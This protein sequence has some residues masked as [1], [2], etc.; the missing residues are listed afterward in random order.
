MKR[1]QF[2]IT[3]IPDGVH[4][5]E[6]NYQNGDYIIEP[7]EENHFLYILVAGKAGVYNECADGEA[8]LLYEYRAVDFFGEFE[9]L[10]EVRTPMTVIAKSDCKV[11]IV[12]KNEVLKWLRMDFEFTLFFLNRICMKTLDLSYEHIRVAKLS[13]RERYIYSIKAH[14]DKGDLPQLTK[15]RLVEEIKAPIRSM[16]RIIADCADFIAF[17]QKTFKIIDQKRFSSEFEALKRKSE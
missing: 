17:E 10:T 5:V 15:E 12:E 13:I 8:V 14:S 16:N 3:E 11:Y 6:K 9:I 7:T 4:F 2:S 1:V